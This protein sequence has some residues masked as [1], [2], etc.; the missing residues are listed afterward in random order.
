MNLSGKRVGKTG[1]YCAPCPFKSIGTDRF[2]FWPQRGTWYCRYDCADCPGEPADG[3][4][5]GGRK[6]FMDNEDLSFVGISY[7]NKK[8]APRWKPN[9]EELLER[10]MYYHDL[11]DDEALAYLATRGI[12]EETAMFFYLG[13]SAGHAVTFPNIYVKRR[14]GEMV[15]YG[16]K[17][18]SMMA[19]A[20]MRYWAEKGT[21]GRSLYNL[22]AAMARPT[23]LLIVES[24]V[25][26][27]ML[28]CL[29]IPAVAPY[30]GGKIWEQ[31]WL[32]WIRHHDVYIV[33]DID[34]TDAAG[35]NAGVDAAL[36][37]EQRIPDSVIVP[38]PGYTSQE[39]YDMGD[40]YQD[41][42][43]IRGWY[44]QL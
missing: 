20:K 10:A 11:L 19:N 8:T 2:H 41:G 21:L 33:Q 22:N 6:G 7:A 4:G 15:C 24:I 35:H 37:K 17:H 18:R 25:E 34:P 40:A 30:G 1:E 3:D 38:P 5:M 14:T 31:G 23:K 27:P 13:R 29:G 36:E 44:E 32:K 16:V 9:F 12:D 39:K 28:H 26:V 42:I 43:D